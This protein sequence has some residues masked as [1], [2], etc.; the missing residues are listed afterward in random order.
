MKREVAVLH[1]R[2]QGVGFRERVIAIARRHPIAG[3]VR[4]LHDGGLEIDVEGDEAAVDRF[5]ADVQSHPP[6]FG[7]VESVSRETRVPR[8]ASDFAVAPS[9]AARKPG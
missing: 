5:L 2:V 6:Y 9:G 8:G 1:G 7:A 4:N 3:S